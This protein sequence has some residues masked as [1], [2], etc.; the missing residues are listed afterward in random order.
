MFSLN[1]FFVAADP[2]HCAHNRRE[3]L[4]FVNVFSIIEKLDWIASLSVSNVYSTV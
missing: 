3:P 4:R 1:H 2:S